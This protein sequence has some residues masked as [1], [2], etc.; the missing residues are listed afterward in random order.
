ML[1]RY[2]ISKKKK[3]KTLISLNKIFL[4]FYKQLEK[5]WLQNQM[6]KLNYSQFISTY[7]P[8]T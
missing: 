7:L 8:N 2:E 6:L 3:K 1:N 4:T 5:S